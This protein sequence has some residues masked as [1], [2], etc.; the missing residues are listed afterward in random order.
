M[1]VFTFNS[2]P[3]VVA[4]GNTTEHTIELANPRSGEK[5]YAITVMVGAFQIN[6]LGPINSG[7][8]THTAGTDSAKT[9]ITTRSSKIVCYIKGAGTTDSLNISEL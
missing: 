8:S 9:I 6:A 4:P 5:T 7:S 3:R 2:N 1:S